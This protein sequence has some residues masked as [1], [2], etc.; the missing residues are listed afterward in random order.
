M[1]RLEEKNYLD[2]IQLVYRSGRVSIMV[3]GAIGWDW[4]SPLILL[5]KEKGMRGIYS[6][7][8]LNQ[9]LEPVVFI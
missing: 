1:C 2:Y 9:V 3:W 7:A 8:Y 5:I 4:K 6:K